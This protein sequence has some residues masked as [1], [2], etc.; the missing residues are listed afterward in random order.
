M[1]YLHGAEILDNNVYVKSLQ[2]T[3]ATKT[4]VKSRH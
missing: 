4:T 3:K 1:K 2:E